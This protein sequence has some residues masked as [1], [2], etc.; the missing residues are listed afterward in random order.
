MVYLCNFIEI[1]KKCN[2][3]KVNIEKVK[4][5]LSNE[6]IKVAKKR[7]NRRCLYSK[8]D[9]WMLIVFVHLEAKRVKKEVILKSDFLS[10]LKRLRKLY[11]KGRMDRFLNYDE[12]RMVEDFKQC[13]NLES[14][15]R[16][17]I[18]PKDFHSI[19]EYL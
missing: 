19:V 10:N 5:Y 2:D 14:Y 1:V 18:N 15:L 13:V 16:F 8:D 12:N 7:E 9:V 6:L 17:K 11:Y 3:K 4:K